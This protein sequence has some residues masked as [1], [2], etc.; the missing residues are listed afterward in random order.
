M[1]DEDKIR[2]VN[3]AVE[4]A[5]R[6]IRAKHAGA[7][8]DE[9][10]KYLS[11]AGEALKQDKFEEAIELAKRAQLA[12]RPTTEYPLSKARELVA[13]AEN[14]FQSKNYANAIEQW[15]KAIE[16]YDRAGELA[17]ER[18]E[19]EIVDS[20]AGVKSK[21]K[22]NITKAEIAIDNRKMLALVDKGN[23][24]VEEANRLFEAKKYEE[25][26][27]SYEES[28]KAFKEALSLAEKNSFTGDKAK[29]EEALK[30]VEASIEAVL[31]SKGDAML[32][33]AEE[34]LE[35]KKF[36]EAEKGFSSAL[37]YLKALEIEKKKEFDEMLAA[38]REGL[39]KSKL[40]QGKEKMREAG[41]LFKSNKYYESKEGY[42]A[43]RDYLE[44]LLEEATSYKLSKLVEELGSLINAC[45]QNIRAATI[46]LMDV[47]GVEPEIILVDEARKGIADF[48]RK[49]KL[50]PVLTRTVY[51]PVKDI[52]VSDK[53]LEYPEIKKW[54]NSH[55]PLDYWYILRIDNLGIIIEQWAVELET[56][57]ALSVKEAFI[58]GF[59][60]SLPLNKEHIQW[61]DKY[62]LRVPKELGIP[63]PSNGTRRLYFRLN[64]DCTTA[65][66]PRYAIS[67][68]VVAK[69][70]IPIPEKDFSYSCELRTL[71][72]VWAKKPKEVEKYV[73]GK[74]RELYSL[75][76]ARAITDALRLYNETNKLVERDYV[77]ENKLRSSIANLRASLENVKAFTGVE[78]PLKLI[79]ESF[80]V[81][82]TASVELAMKRWKDMNLFEVMMTELLKGRG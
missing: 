30:T 69:D 54:I 52:F 60:R 74:A 25:S 58:D 56:H 37:E 5:I 18:K 39:I 70:V 82:E 16:E 46:P 24:K 9:A 26:N 76:A 2:E 31:L 17:K 41:R 1:S 42:K 81:M 65:L 28:K 33:E 7:N 62:V 77:E 50:A 78:R 19:Q 21:I 63:L 13:S 34:S 59:E 20:V 36:T 35:K 32:Q 75:D 14:N 11:E 73:D 72:K 43:A 3:E 57:I 10:R 4:E 38:G 80:A 55:P 64:I 51:D 48:Q 22:Y 53:K 29:I 45:G 49:T 27:K 8:L 71:K 66:L 44:S 61:K 68:R 79:D 6:F 12:A 15:N 23:S 67:G 47:G 40:E